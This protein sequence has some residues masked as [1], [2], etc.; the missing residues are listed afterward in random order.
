[1]IGSQIPLKL[2]VLMKKLII[3]VDVSKIKLDYCVYNGNV[4][5]KG[6]LKY[7]DKNMK[8]LFDP[9]KNKKEDVLVVM[10][11]TGTYHL[12]LSTFLT[13]ND[14]PYSIVNPFTIKKY[15]E[16]KMLRAKTDAVDAKLISIFGYEQQPPQ[17]KP[18]SKEQETMISLL[19]L[20]DDF[21]QTKTDYERR[22][23]AVKQNPA[24]SKIIINDIKSTIKYF[25]Q[26]IEEREKDL[27][28]L[29]ITHYSDEFNRYKNIISVG[30]KTAA[31][32]VAYFGSFENFETSKQVASYIG[33][34]P[35]P[36]ISGK[37][38][39]GRGKISK[40]GNGYIRKQLYM[41]SLSAI[42]HNPR[43]KVFYERLRANGKEH[44][45]AR[46]ATMNKLMKQIFAIGKY[47]R[48]YDP[49]YAF[50]A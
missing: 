1:M 23:E 3:G 26:K 20:I 17:F 42:Q 9:Y 10:E 39:R 16:V 7:D 49:N 29:V 32:F 40:K 22:L 8:K 33:I 27:Y 2:G 18:K 37:S 6:E 44:K 25:Q 36:K 30:N 34:N 38:V 11:A 13:T 47:N 41:A 35:S 28:N 50:N 43:C 5:V 12:R 46:V 19:K 31:I 14:I 21:I 15:A 24:N 48:N 4:V 45:V